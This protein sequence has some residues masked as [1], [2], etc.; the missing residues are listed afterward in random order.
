M[1]AVTF[2]ESIPVRKTGLLN[3][4]NFSDITKQNELLFARFPDFARCG[5]VVMTFAVLAP[6]RSQYRLQT[7]WQEA[8][9]SE[10]DAGAAS[11]VREV[12]FAG[13]G[14]RP[15]FLRDEPLANFRKG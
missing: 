6:S 3:T 7:L 8:V 9:C 5:L 10:A 2:I 14:D 11:P 1:T 4:N 13:T 15:A 12:Q